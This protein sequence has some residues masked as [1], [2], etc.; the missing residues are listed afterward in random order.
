MPR[1]WLFTKKQLIM[2]IILTES[3][4]KYLLETS[5]S[6]IDTEA[7]NVNLNPTEPQKEAGNYK[8]GHVSIK[9]MGIS[10]ENPKG[11]K[12]KYKKKKGK[13]KKKN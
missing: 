3:Q 5:I 8:M 11:S 10:I 1:C 7:K 12:R 4:L 9:G 13:K 6:E 2:K